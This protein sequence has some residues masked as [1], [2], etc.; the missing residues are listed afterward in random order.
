M[1]EKKMSGFRARLDYVLKHNYLINRTF[2]FAMSTL[3]RAWGCFVRTDDM[4]IIFSG[5]SRRYNDSPRA[6]YEYIIANVEYSGY[7]FVWALE[8]PE[9]V[10]IPGPAIKIKSDNLRYFKYTLKAKYWISCVNIERSL[11]YKK[12]DCIYLNTWHG[13]SI[14]HIGN[15]VPGRKDFDFSNVDFLCYESDYHKQI[16]IRDLNARESAMI[17]T[18]LPRNDELYRTS[19]DEI[20]EIKIKLGLP[21][22]KKIILYAP[23]WRDS[24]DSGKTYSLKP[25]I[26]MDLW[27]Q[28]LKDKYIVLLRTHAYTNSLLGVKFDEFVRD[29]SSYNSINQLFKISDILISDYSACIG[30]FSILE[31]PIICFAYDYEAYRDKRGLYLDLEKAM[32]SGVMRTEQEVLDFIISMDYVKEC[33][34]TREMIKNKY[35]YLGG[36][37][38]RMCVDKVF[39]AK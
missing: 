23:T 13:L 33:E 3:M 1:A 35:T 15:A 32:P 10:N 34:K 31:R 6:I 16:L 21:M 28:R 38:T 2:R 39:N 22:D 29:F 17:G 8:D 18:G 37:A 7:K 19:E 9:N 20:K 5:H 11:S 36:D 4:L 24:D 27:K 25:P 12:K 14:N 30:D 26:N